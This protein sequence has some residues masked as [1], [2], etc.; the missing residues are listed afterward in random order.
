MPTVPAMIG[1]MSPTTLRV[2]SV[3]VMTVA[4]T[5]S[6]AIDGDVAGLPRMVSADT[7]TAASRT[8]SSS[9]AIEIVDMYAQ[10]PV[11]DDETR[12]R[13]MTT[14]WAQSIWTLPHTSA[15]AVANVAVAS[16]TYVTLRPSGEDTIRSSGRSA[17][18]T[19]STI[20]TKLLPPAEVVR[21]NSMAGR[22]ALLDRGS[23]ACTTLSVIVQVEAP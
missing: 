4:A 22:S 5:R 15:A 8:L 13:S 20:A 9:R 6:K 16:S 1:M 23:T 17:R 3:R 21:R 11:V 12:L 19:L 2:A 7:L 18:M 10:L 14:R